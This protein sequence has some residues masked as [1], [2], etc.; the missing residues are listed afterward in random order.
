MCRSARG[1]YLD[2]TGYAD[3]P[4][5]SAKFSQHGVCQVFPRGCIPPIDNGRLSCQPLYRSFRLATI[6]RF[7]AAPMETL[8]H[9]SRGEVP[10]V[11]K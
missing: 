11:R 4:A 8:G 3:C 6:A 9:G 10:T 2:F 1:T 5:D 7:V